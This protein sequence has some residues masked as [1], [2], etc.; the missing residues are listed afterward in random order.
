MWAFGQSVYFVMSDADAAGAR[1]H[2]PEKYFNPCMVVCFAEKIAYER[3][4]EELTKQEYFKAVTG[5]QK[6]DF[7][8]RYGAAFS[9]P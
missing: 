5:F 4:V 8:H 9:D 6:L 3:I 2:A 1:A 7:Y